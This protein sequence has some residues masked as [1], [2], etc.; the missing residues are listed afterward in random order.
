MFRLLVALLA[1][2]G[3]GMPAI[4]QA[5]FYRDRTLNLLVNYGAGGNADLEARVFQQFLKKYIP[6]APPVVVQNAPGAGGINAMNMLGMNIGSRADG[7]TLGY[8]TFGPISSIAGDPA[9]KIDI[10]DFAVVGAMKSW[11]LAYG[12]KD[13][14]PG[15]R[16]PVDLAHAQKVYLGGYSRSSLHDTRLRLAMEILGIPYE[17]VTGFQSTS[18]LNKAM[19][20]NEIN[21][22]SSTL[23][24]YRTQVVPQVV[25]AGVGMPLFEFPAMDRDGLPAKVPALASIGV[26]TFDALYREAFGRPPSG[27]KWDALL[28]VNHLGTQIQRL[29]VFPKGTPADAVQTLRTALQA[30]ARDPEFIT[31]YEKITGEMPI[32]APA[33]EV[34]PAI[35]R[36]KTVSPEIRK[37]LQQSIAE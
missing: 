12:R 32:I 36:I 6:G 19:V 21:L 7:A 31:A 14:P 3:V 26:P 27:P 2:L 37:V 4:A 29:I 18:A 23:P 9:L 30:L 11:A 8:F 22:S 34:E 13:I 33:D 5:Q 10:S 25:D 1:A 35:A 20:Q 28:L 17:M 15:I 24:G 16:T